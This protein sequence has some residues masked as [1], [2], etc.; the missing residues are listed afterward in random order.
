[1]LALVAAIVVAVAVCVGLGQRG[2]RLLFGLLILAVSVPLFALSVAALW[3]Q[4]HGWIVAA[5][6]VV[7]FATVS[8]VVKR[9][10]G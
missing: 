7:A 4:Y 9:V 10:R 2:L 3:P 1:M 6:A 8:E 5:G